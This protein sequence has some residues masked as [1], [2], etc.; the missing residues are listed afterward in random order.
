MGWAGDIHREPGSLWLVPT[1]PVT[2]QGWGRL[3]LG[4]G[5]PM[6]PS[7]PG[8]PYGRTASHGCE[9][10]LGRGGRPPCGADTH[11][12]TLLSR[13]SRLPHVALGALKAENRKRGK[14]RQG[15]VGHQGRRL[16]PGR[17]KSENLRVSVSRAAGPAQGT[18]AMPHWDMPES[19][20]PP[21]SDQ[22]L[23]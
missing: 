7:M 21:L 13:L 23:F 11:L 10:S 4:P 22:G 14:L 2:G 1:S 15:G 20:Q 6:G 18:M 3:A 19:G 8:S 5:N 9:P 12:P 16:A 17:W